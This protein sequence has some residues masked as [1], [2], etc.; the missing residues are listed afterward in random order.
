MYP[1]YCHFIHSLTKNLS[2]ENISKI[3]IKLYN[4][5]SKLLE[6]Y[7]QTFAKLSSFSYNF[8]SYSLFCFTDFNVLYA[9]F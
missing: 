2:F 3:L 1:F 5:N 9:N 7:K 8:D 6:L 4:F